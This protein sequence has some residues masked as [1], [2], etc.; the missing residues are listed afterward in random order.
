MKSTLKISKFFPINQT[1]TMVKS[2]GVS[3]QLQKWLL[4]YLFIFFP[5]FFTLKLKLALVIPRI[6]VKFWVLKMKEDKQTSVMG[7]SWKGTKFSCFTHTK[8][9]FRVS[10]GLFKWLGS[11]IQ[12]DSTWNLH[13]AFFWHLFQWLAGNLT[14]LSF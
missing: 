11:N 3:L 7:V 4:V 1:T 6:V 12:W 13:P 9:D 2:C 8:V 5:F 10:L 14:N